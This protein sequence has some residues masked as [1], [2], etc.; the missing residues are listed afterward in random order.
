MSTTATEV[1]PKGW[2][3]KAWP[4]GAE[5]F[6]N[7]YAAVTE[8]GHLDP[9]T[10]LLIMLVG[11]SQGRCRH[12]VG[13]QIDRLKKEVG[14]TNQEIAEAMMLASLAAAGTNMAWAKEV[15]DEKLS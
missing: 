3:E 5:A 7:F 9:K 11:A 1:K 4:Q 15:F 8:K 12:C 2:M 10:R 14:A 13:G 6:G